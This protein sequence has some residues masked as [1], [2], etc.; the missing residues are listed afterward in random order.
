M[1]MFTVLPGTLM[2]GFMFP[3]EA[4]PPILQAL[5]YLI[6]LT[7]FLQILRGTILKGVGIEALW[8]QALFLAVFALGISALSIMRFRRSLA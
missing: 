6:P 3:R 4:M 1:A 2:S 7:Y 5:S 8:S